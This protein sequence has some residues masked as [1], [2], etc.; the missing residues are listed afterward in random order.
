MATN[1]DRQSQ[2]ASSSGYVATGRGAL[3]FGLGIVIALLIAR[4]IDMPM[5]FLAPILA[6][7][8][9]VPAS[10]PPTPIKLVALPIVIGI[11]TSLTKAVASV[12]APMPDVL[13]AR[14]IHDAA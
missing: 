11:L 13:L 4:A 6:V 8:L 5:A 3:R 14:I 7:S 12:L 9:L 2:G 1:I 10:V